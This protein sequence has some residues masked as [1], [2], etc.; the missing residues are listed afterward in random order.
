VSSDSGSHH[1]SENES[2]QS[3]SVRKVVGSSSS[4]VS[5]DLSDPD[6]DGSHD[7]ERR[8]IMEHHDADD[9]VDDKENAQTFI[10]QKH[11]NKRKKEK[12]MVEISTQTKDDQSPVTMVAMEMD[13]IS[14]Q[15]IGHDKLFPSRVNSRRSV[16][17][18]LLDNE[19]FEKL[20]ED[21]QHLTEQKRKLELDIEISKEDNKILQAESSMALEKENLRKIVRLQ[22]IEH[23]LQ[24]Q[25]EE[26]EKS[27]KIL[28]EKN[29][30]LLEEKCELEEAEN[31]SRLQAQR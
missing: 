5:S 22:E 11:G 31:D 2:S 9:E 8:Q 29:R 15:L 10:K 20:K 12:I 16:D 28:Q 26:W 21:Y 1:S 7:D 17:E 23:K 19:N 13:K 24:N 18:V 4:G 30:A 27:Y 6:S 3:G 14:T 25:L